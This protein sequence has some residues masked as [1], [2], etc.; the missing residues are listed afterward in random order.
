MDTSAIADVVGGHHVGPA[1]PVRHVVLEADRFGTDAVG[2]CVATEHRDGTATSTSLD[3]LGRDHVPH[4]TERPP[5]AGPAIVVR[6]TALALRHLASTIRPTLA[7]RA[8][9]VTGGSGTSSTATWL[10]RL[11]DAA[12]GPSSGADLW[13]DHRAAT[14]VLNAGPQHRWVVADTTRRHRGCEADDGQLLDPDIVVVA[15]PGPRSVAT[16]GGD[17]A[18]LA[19]SRQ[20]V[21]RCRPSLV[22]VPEELADQFGSAAVSTYDRNGDDGATRFG[23]SAPP[24]ARAACAAAGVPADPVE[25]DIAAPDHITPEGVRV[26]DLGQRVSAGDVLIGLDHLAG[27]VTAGGGS[28]PVVG[29]FGPID[30]GPLARRRLEPWLVQQASARGIV[31]W[32]LGRSDHGVEPF[33]DPEAAA[34]D[35]GALGP[36]ATVLLAGAA[37]AAVRALL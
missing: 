22:V 6:D 4:L 20:L 2:L 28:A 37:T 21:D 23:C 5:V 26:V 25:C 24:A 31:V 10:V 11:L 27:A 33:E 13:E 8:I 17:D 7:A 3:R 16:L 29:L 14:A 15:G 12:V 35:I 30:D 18:W 9:A 32:S 1:A 34:A 19:E 36:G